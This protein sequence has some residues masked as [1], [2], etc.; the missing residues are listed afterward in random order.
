MKIENNAGASNVP[1]GIAEGTLLATQRAFWHAHLVER[2]TPNDHVASLTE[3]LEGLRESLSA[4]LR[5][6]IA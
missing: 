4:S 3:F 6:I 2:Y 1:C 5:D